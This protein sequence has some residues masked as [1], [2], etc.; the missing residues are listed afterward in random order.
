MRR[1]LDRILID[2]ARIAERVREMGVELA[3]QLEGEL[4]A[5]G[6]S[7]DEAGHAVMIPVLTG[8]MIFVAD[9]VREMP[10]KLS[11]GL[12]AVSSYPGKSMQ[13][14]GASI[15]SELPPDL[16]GKHVVIAD[17]ILD[18][19]NTLA[20][21]KRLV[22]EKKPASVRVVVLLR[23]ILPGHTPPIEADL[24]GF[25]IPDEFVVGYGLDYDGL[26]RNLPEIAVLRP[27]AL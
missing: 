15:A 1:D 5:E 13:S 2:R 23:K 20:L 25:E 17:D 26:Y 19:G 21:V 12:V 9:L 18:T 3:R 8:S 16:A 7:P 22:L 6:A 24:V 14:K 11:L 4:Q 10:M 27:E